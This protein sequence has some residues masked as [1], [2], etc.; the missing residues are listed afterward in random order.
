M[1]YHARGVTARYE[2]SFARDSKSFITVLESVRKRLRMHS[3]GQSANG[4][5]RNAWDPQMH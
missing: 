1:G 5:L 4:V 3:K 2:Q